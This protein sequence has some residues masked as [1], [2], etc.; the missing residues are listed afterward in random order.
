MRDT[1]STTTPEIEADLKKISNYFWFNVI[2]LTGLLIGALVLTFAFG[3]VG[4]G[5]KLLVCLLYLVMYF[6]FMLRN[7]EMRT[8]EHTWVSNGGKTE[9]PVKKTPSPHTVATRPA[10]PSQ[11]GSKPGMAPIDGGNK[12]PT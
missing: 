7:W 10:I 2:L 1:K 12:T 9:P 6:V 11:E 5:R 8:I 4:I 3:P